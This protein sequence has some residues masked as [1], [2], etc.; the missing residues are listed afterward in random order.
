[1]FD[2]FYWHHLFYFVDRWYYNIWLL[3]TE[4]IYKIRI[5]WCGLL[6]V[7]H[8]KYIY[9]AIWDP[10]WS[11][12]IPICSSKLGI[13]LGVGNVRNMI[14]SLIANSQYSDVLV[15]YCVQIC[16]FFCLMR[17]NLKQLLFKTKMIV[18]VS[19]VLRTL[20]R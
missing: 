7:H 3:R 15:I 6:S 9:A 4:G 19:V 14:L 2:V 20:V 17:K 8:L 16:I 5:L 1:M 11:Y 13:E 12:F 18:F 10:L